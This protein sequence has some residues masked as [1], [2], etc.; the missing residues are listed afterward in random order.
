MLSRSVALNI[1]GGFGSLAVGFATSVLLANWLGA[2][3]RG[4][5]GIMITASGVGLAVAGLGLPMAVMYF[6]SR[7]DAS[8]PRLLADTVIYGLLLAAVFIPGAWLLRHQL[9]HLLADGR[10]SRAWI[11]AGVLVPLT[12]LDW[13]THNQLL[14]KLRFGLYNVL[15]ILSKLAT[16]ALVVVLLGVLGF[17]LGGALVATMAASVVMILGS[18]PAILSEGAPRP[19]RA[20]FR[21]LVA[22]GSK[23][24]IGSVLQL[25]NYRLDII[26]LSLFVPLS[27]VGYYFVAAFLAE[28]VV[29]IANAFQSSVL[30]LVSHYDQDDRQRST[31]VAA[32]RHH[33]ILALLA[34]VANAVF[35]PIIIL[36]ALSHDYRPALTP[37]FILLP[38]ML[39]LGLGTVVQGDLRGR[40]RPG[41]SSAYAAVAVVVTVVLDLALIPPFGVVGAAIASVCAYTI[42][43]VVSLRGLSRIS[44]IPLRELAVPRRE[45]LSLYRRNPF[46][47]FARAVPTSVEEG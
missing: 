45:D 41:L 44:G 32:V 19:D 36:V 20:L 30:P 37:F 7:K 16:L 9:S 3:D 31:T 38:S 10:G 17:G 1:L 12:F 22:Y 46:R 35:S 42:Y 47:L 39:F 23:V 21:H 11:L 40:G 43:G 8:G 28:L 18:L 2:A 24:Q 14:G 4:L 34:I 15:V 13:T 5:L 27:E 26:V 29:T 25:L 6:A 33:T